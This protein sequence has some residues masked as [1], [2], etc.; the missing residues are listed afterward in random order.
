MSGPHSLQTQ[1][2]PD[3]V[4]TGAQY[5][6]QWNRPGRADTNWD[7]VNSFPTRQN[8]LIRNSTSDIRP[9]G[10]PRAENEIRCLPHNSTMAKKVNKD[11]TKTYL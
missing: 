11:K 1:S 3:G 10:H 7:L 2:C 9:T 6:E 8:N 4:N 5:G